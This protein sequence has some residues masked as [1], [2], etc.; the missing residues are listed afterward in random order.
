[1][2]KQKVL[3][4]TLLLSFIYFYSDA[5]SWQP[6][7]SN[8]Y[9]SPS[10]SKVGIGTSTFGTEQFSILTPS[11]EGSSSTSRMGIL[12]KSIVSCDKEN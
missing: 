9:I 10:T 1:M 12:A 6:T 2:T 8:L 4:V 3:L 11:I 7:G 5:Q